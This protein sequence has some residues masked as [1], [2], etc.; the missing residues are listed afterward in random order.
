MGA[1]LSQE[2]GKTQMTLF[3]N[4]LMSLKRKKEDEEKKK[5]SKYQN[6]NQ[7]SISGFN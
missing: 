5:T 2:I 7:Y 4:G 6:N 3:F 1:Y